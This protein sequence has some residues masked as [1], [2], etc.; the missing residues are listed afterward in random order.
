MHRFARVLCIGLIVTGSGGPIMAQSGGGGGAIGGIVG[1]V[2]N[3]VGG[4]VGGVGG[5]VGGVGSTVGSLGG[6][7]G[8]LSGPVGGI[9]NT[10]GGIGND[11]SG[12]DNLSIR[13][14]GQT[15]MIAGRLVEGTTETIE[16]TRAEIEREADSNLNELGYSLWVHKVPPATLLDLR[17]LRLAQ[18]V[19]DSGGRLEMDGAGNP[20]VRGRL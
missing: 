9:S 7:I 6:P 4:I 3:T 2:G 11:L 14:G 15:Q 5:T 17:R 12:I 10:I 19:K 18:L 13:P 1:G 20:T 16:I 8:G